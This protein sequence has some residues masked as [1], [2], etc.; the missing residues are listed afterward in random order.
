MS[1]DPFGDFESRGYL[2]NNAGEKD[3]GRVRALEHEA[4]RAALPDAF[5]AFQGVKRIG[6]GELLETHGR[7]F[8]NIYPWAGRDRLELAPDLAIGKAGQ[9]DLFAHP[10][11]VRRAAEFGLD[12]ANDPATIR[13]RPGETLGYLAYAHPFLDGNGRTIL[14]VH[15]ELAR[16]AGFS[17]DWGAIAKEQFLSALTE[18]L[19]RPGAALDQLLAPHVTPSAGAAADLMAGLQTNPGLGPPSGNPLGRLL[20]RGRPAE[21]GAVSGGSESLSDRLDAFERGKQAGTT[22]KDT[23]SEGEPTQEKKP[24]PSSGP[25]F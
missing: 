15:V 24:G 1:F 13:A 25:G 23:G 18:E 11:D 21:S 12:M 10:Q 20:S 4:F 5:A 9:F 16:R 17:I 14:T 2:R 22:A 7:L 3:P 6:Y 19:R 8:G